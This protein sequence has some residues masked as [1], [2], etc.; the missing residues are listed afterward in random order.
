MLHEKNGGLSV[1]GRRKEVRIK[2]NIY[3]CSAPKTD[4][5][6]N[7][8]FF[9]LRLWSLYPRLLSSSVS[10][11]ARFFPYWE[12]CFWP[13]NGWK[14]WETKRIV[15]FRSQVRDKI[16]LQVYSRIIKKLYNVWPDWKIKV[17]YFILSAMQTMQIIPWRKISLRMLR[18]GPDSRNWNA[19]VEPYFHL[20]LRT[21][22]TFCE[23]T[24]SS[25]LCTHGTR[26][27]WIGH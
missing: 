17:P 4:R 21:I 24:S 25:S 22:C 12:S 26:S 10:K 23:M 20:S 11:W 9:I 7:S 3:S 27:F 18:S 19:R 14:K 15:L 2:R 13:S 8:R 5:R 6:N 16:I 1:Q